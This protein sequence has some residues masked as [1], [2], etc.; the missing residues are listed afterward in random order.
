M[1]R[2][3][4][5]PRSPHLTVWK[6]G[7]HML[8]SIL[9]RVTGVGLATVGVTGFVG[10]LVALASGKEAYGSFMRWAEWPPMWVFPIGL[11]AAFF[12]HL[13]NGLRHFVFVELGLGAFIG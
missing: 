6:W 9:N 3:T 8:V 4:A 11:T 5:R 10:W 7:P 13:C 2:N 1:I 12:F